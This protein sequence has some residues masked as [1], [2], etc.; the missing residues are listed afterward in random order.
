ME[1]LL[2]TGFT[3]CAWW[4]ATAA[5]LRL[6]RMSGAI[7]TT[8]LL[9]TSVLAVAAVGGLIATRDS[10]SVTAIYCSFTCALILFAWHEVSY[11]AG[12]V[13]GPR[14]EGCPEGAN[15][16]QRF[17]FG[18]AASLYHELAIIATAAALFW[19]LQGGNTMALWT[20]C[21][22]WWM[23]WSAKLNIFLGVANLHAEFW[24]AHLRYLDSY[25]AHRSMNLLF[26]VSITVA[27]GAVGVMIYQVTQ[28][29]AGS[30][31]STAQLLLASLLALAILEHW[32]LVLPI[33]D[34]ALWK[35]S[36]RVQ[37]EQ[38]SPAG[39]DARSTVTADNSI[40]D[41][42]VDTRVSPDVVALPRSAP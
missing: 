37:P 31:Q 13:S 2:P 34:D 18:V 27:T 42:A 10:H 39:E 5:V 9:L 20:F 25:V 28:L 24:P 8:G 15:S 23:R 12:L 38:S 26:P 6:N 36:T 17:R 41:S 33:A 22:L 16:W 29:P 35:W 7:A 1:Y 4:L 21:L 14:P 40:V 19:W 3:I 30:P 32:F 11:Y